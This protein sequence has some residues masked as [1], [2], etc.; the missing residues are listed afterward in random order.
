MSTGRRASVKTHAEDKLEARRTLGKSLKAWRILV[1]QTRTPSSSLIRA[2]Q[3]GWKGPALVS[4]ELNL[5]A[6]LKRLQ[7]ASYDAVLLGQKAPENDGGR[8][9]K[10]I[11]AVAPKTVVLVLTSRNEEWIAHAAIRRGFQSYLVRKQV[12]GSS[13]VLAIEYAV[14]KVRAIEAALSSQVFPPWLAC[15]EDT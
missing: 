3:T 13:L 2:L 8:S 14:G 11:H 9:L 1:V 6:A 5:E 4:I 7:T 10:R 15:P 12:H